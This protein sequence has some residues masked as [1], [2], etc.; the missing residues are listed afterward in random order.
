MQ[1]QYFATE[2]IIFL[3][4]SLTSHVLNFSS[5]SIRN[6]HNHY[7][8]CC[9]IIP[10]AVRSSLIERQTLDFFNMRNSFNACSAHEGEIGTKFAQVSIGRLN[11][12]P[13]SCRVRESNLRH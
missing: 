7:F 3:I 4:E 8:G 13:S 12:G 9:A 10:P 11:N 5:S 6:S 1:F 2:G